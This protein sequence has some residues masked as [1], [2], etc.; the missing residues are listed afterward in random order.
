[1]IYFQGFRS[2]LTMA[3]H[4]QDLSQAPP[5]VSRPYRRT[6]FSLLIVIFTVAAAAGGWV[7]WRVHVC[8]PRLDGT[9][10]IEGLQGKVEVL[11]DAH[12]VP[13]IR[14]S[15]LEDLMFAQGYVTA[16]DRLWQMDLSRRIA[17][18]RLSEL[19]G[20]RTLHSDI[21]NRTLGMEQAAE[22]GVNELDPE[23][24]KL[25]LDYAR[26][27]NAFIQTHQNRLPVE[28]LLLRYHPTPWQASNSLE[29]AL[30]M[31]R[32]L[33]TSWPDDLMRERVRA[34]LG[35]TQ[36]DSELFPA[37]SPL[38]HPVAQMSPSAPAKPGPVHSQ[39]SAQTDDQP[40]LQEFP[41]ANLAWDTKGLAG[42]D[43]MLQAL[44][45]P[46][47]YTG[48]GSN[49]W[50][51]S[52]AHTRSGK[53]LLANDPHLPF[54]VPSVWYMVQLEAPG[55]DVTGVSLPGL[56]M[57]I[58]GHN[59]HIAWGVTNTGPDVQ[60]L[61][62]ETFN[63]KDPHEYLDDGKWVEASERTERIKV[64]D[65]LD[66]ILQVESTRHG[67]IISHADNRNLALAW[68]ALLPRALQFPFLKIDEAKN[69]QEFTDALRSFAGP[70]QNFV[71]ADTQGNIG[72]YAAGWVPIRET[73]DGSVPVP[74]SS[75]GYEWSGVVPFQD[76]PHAYNP[77]SGILAT[78]N[79]RVVPEDY[80]YFITSMW[81]APYR[82]ARI[83]QLL[84]S[85]KLL[86]VADMLKIQMDIHPLDDEWLQKHLITAAKEYPPQA[87]EVQFAMG[88]LRS[89][90]EEATASSTATLVCELTW[91]ALL[92]Q[93]L[94][95]RLGKDLAGYRCPMSRVFLQNTID[96]NM[97]Q[98]LPPADRDFNQTLMKS[99][100][101]AVRQIPK[102][103]DT[104]NHSAWKWGKTIP[105]TFHHPLGG[106]SWLLGW[107][108]NVGP[109]PQS[110]TASTI[111]RATDGVGPSMR[112]VVDLA[113][114]D[115][116]V[117]N[118]TLGESGQVFSP[119]YKDQ[120]EAWYHG[121]SFAMKFSD[122]SVQKETAHR[123]VLEPAG[124]KAGG[125]RQ[126]IK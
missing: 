111:K 83:Y 34:K 37:S 12:G 54:G 23:E 108:M 80:P 122:A 45:S 25:L 30:N 100:Q 114:L 92:D 96:N 29:V 110:G 103:M 40:N 13:H 44:E 24:R 99:L 10:R 48:V 85:G 31:A 118:I 113:D 57:V 90:D 38:D 119:Y 58:I 112:M 106:A 66:Q 28:F 6:V 115:D 47:S 26:G 120:F 33:N 8:L 11:R 97:D 95:P 101:A 22:R 79:S 98:W 55:I 73:G 56:P 88:K 62:E 124:T 91:Q 102:F 87:P 36:L 14:A 71:Y 3:T 81:G 19:F 107:L 74:G 69:W 84:E 20:S 52:G 104:G 17:Q 76:L 86:T 7:Y 59:R 78:A 70:M 82:T 15:S 93:I 50:V 43:P 1:M 18:G 77:A 64:R 121:Q 9:L 2:F 51:V 63:P 117:Q 46:S 67:P 39:S 41:S 53:P 109:Y 123:L 75:D 49:N 105:L 60:D 89:W 94:E 125:T 42:L 32:L 61:Y 72:F 5:R 126:E 21:E 27:V 68:T 116:S 4:P 35:S 16:Q 65:K